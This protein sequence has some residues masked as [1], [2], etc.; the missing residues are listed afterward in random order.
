MN[1]A[2]LHFQALL[3]ESSAYQEQATG[4]TQTT[5]APVC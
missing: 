4:C 2:V 5:E 1:P 3:K